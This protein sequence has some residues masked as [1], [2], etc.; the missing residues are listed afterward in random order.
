M[1]SLGGFVGG[2][3]S[4]E[5]KSAAV[6]GASSLEVRKVLAPASDPGR[7]TLITRYS[8][9]ALIEQTPN[10]GNGTTTGRFD[11]PAGR[12][13]TVEEKAGANTKLSDYTSR[14]DC[15]IVS[16]PDMG[17]VFPTVNGTATKFIAKPGDGYT[18]T[19]TNTRNPS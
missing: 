19:F 17:Q 18:C 13:L 9:G 12:V 1:A 7:F 3:R 8:F 6:G 16:G 2:A 11:I 14:L 5:P 4:A 10:A 15:R